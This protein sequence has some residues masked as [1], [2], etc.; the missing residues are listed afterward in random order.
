MGFPQLV[1]LVASEDNIVAVRM[2]AA[3]GILPGKTNAQLFPDN[4][5]GK[6]INPWDSERSPGVSS[7][8]SFAAIATA[9]TP[10]D[11]GSDGG[12]E[13]TVLAYY[14]G[15]FGKRP[16]EWGVPDETFPVDPFQSGAHVKQ[17]LPTVDLVA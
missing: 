1:E 12:V 2:K 14:T 15:I 9:M 10:L 4:P 8:G 3:E 6:T 11:F 5:F 13:I 16:V 7:A 17:V